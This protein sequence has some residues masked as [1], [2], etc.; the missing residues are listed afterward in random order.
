MSNIGFGQDR[1]YGAFDEDDDFIE[2]WSASWNPAGHTSVDDVPDSATETHPE[3]ESSEQP[4]TEMFPPYGS[5]GSYDAAPA[6]AAPADEAAP[7]EMFPP[8]GSSSLAETPAPQEPAP[9]EMFPQYGSYAAAT[10]AG[11]PSQAGPGADSVDMFQ[12]PADDSE[13]AESVAEVAEPTPVADPYDIESIHASVAADTALD[14]LSE[15]IVSAH[16][17]T[18]VATPAPVAEPFFEPAPTSTEPAA[19]DSEAAW[20]PWQAAPEQGAAPETVPE[21]VEGNESEAVAV[22]ETGAPEEADTTP[23]AA[24]EVPS[25]PAPEPWTEADLTPDTSAAPEAADLE[26]ATPEAVAPEV[27][28]PEAGEPVPAPLI[29][30]DDVSDLDLVDWE[31]LPMAAS[32][33]TATE[34]VPESGLDEPES[35]V[36]QFAPSAALA[37]PESAVAPEPEPVAEPEPEPDHS[38]GL[39]GAAAAGLAAAAAWGVWS[40]TPAVPSMP[41]ENPMHLAEPEPEAALPAEP[42]PVVASPFAPESSEVTEPEPEP[43]EPGLPVPEPEVLTIPEPQPSEF[44]AEAPL[45][46]SDVVT[47]PIP[48]PDMYAAPGLSTFAVPEPEPFV[49]PE[50][51]PFGEPSSAAPPTGETTPIPEPGF[52]APVMAEPT[53]MMGAETPELPE[54]ASAVAEAAQPVAPELAAHEQIHAAAGAH[55]AYDL[56]VDVSS[57]VGVAMRFAPAESAGVAPRVDD[58][59]RQIVVNDEA[60]AAMFARSAPTHEEPAVEPAP[61]DEPAAGAVVPEAVP[62]YPF[63]APEPAWEVPQVEAPQ[64]EAHEAAEQEPAADPWAF[65]P[66]PVPD[67]VFAAPEGSVPSWTLPPASAPHAAPEPSDAP[68]VWDAPEQAWAPPA[69]NGPEV[70]ADSVPAAP[71]AEPQQGQPE[72]EGEHSKWY[73]RAKMWAANNLYDPDEDESVIEGDATHRQDE[74]NR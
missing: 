66:P 54:P 21:L 27:E 44:A 29:A 18:P 13:P 20:G 39:T 32:D 9:A 64:V 26:S 70:A 47:T 40:G 1:P 60:A 36:S 59:E 30:P 62:P 53:P 24:T 67:S 43:Y 74:Q 8:Y 22:P 41:A 52:P 10:E 19:S 73:D 37:E 50:P 6:V 69:E 11:E 42:E 3:P 56:A 4:P 71:D 38:V 51:E 28:A 17:L 45:A 14:D 46:P 23:E 35:E 57:I 48:D 2:E 15:A 33:R 55:P 72:H 49:I 34:F 31:P 16:P 12:A 7:T 65:S 58:S 25:V 61:H 63:S 5:Q 68:P